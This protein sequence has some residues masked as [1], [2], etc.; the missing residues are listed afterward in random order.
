MSF[1]DQQFIYRYEDEFCKRAY[2]FLRALGVINKRL[3]Y[4][5]H[6]VLSRDPKPPHAWAMGWKKNKDKHKSKSYNT[7]ITFK[8][9]AIVGGEVEEG[10]P[11]VYDLDDEAGW[12]RVLDAQDGRLE[13]IV[14]EEIELWERSAFE[15]TAGARFSVVNQTS[16][17]AEASAFDIASASAESVTTISAETSFAARQGMERNKRRK[18]AIQ[19][20]LEADAG[21]KVLY[22]VEKFR[23]KVITPVLDNGYL[24]FEV[25][26]DLWDWAEDDQ[27]WLRDSI[28]VGGNRIKCDNVAAILAFMEGKRE[29]EYP[30]MVGFLPAMRKRRNDWWAAKGTLEFY[31]WLRNVERRQVSLQG[32]RVQYIENASTMRRQPLD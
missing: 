28:D 19:S 16:V 30:N 6:F 29:H 20:K 25:E 4:N 12:S 15:Y 22:T 3:R 11:T 27:K 9:H 26:F 18:F 1:N 31:D 14:D 13:E 5:E 23:R 10:K 2:P 21:E 8:G 17:K 32:Q 24:D 7:R